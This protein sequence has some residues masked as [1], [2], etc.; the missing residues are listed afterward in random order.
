MKTIQEILNGLSKTE[1]LVVDKYDN[2]AIVFDRGISKQI[3]QEKI[4]QMYEIVDI[5]KGL[6]SEID[7]NGAINELIQKISDKVE[8]RRML[9]QAI[10]TSNPRDIVEAIKRLREEKLLKKAKPTRGCYSIKIPGKKGQ[11]PI[12]LVLVS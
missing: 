1:Y 8:L 11:R 3:G 4:K 12:E 9:K 2:M 5:S 10:S 7:V 6:V